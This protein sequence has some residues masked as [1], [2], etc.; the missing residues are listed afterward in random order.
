[1]KFSFRHVE[2]F[3]AVMSSGSATAAAAMLYTSQPTISRELSRFEKLTGLELFRRA[4]SKLVPTEQA[5]MLYDEVQRS[6]FGL[7]RIA[8]AADAIRH[9]RQTQLTVICLP[10]LSHGLLP[11]VCQQLRRRHTGISISVT[12]QESPALQEALSAQ[13]YHLG[14]TEDKEAP[15]GTVVEVL[16]QA[17]VVCVLPAGHALCSRQVLELEDFEGQDFVCLAAEDPYRI[18]TDKLFRERGVER[19][20]VV[21]THSASA[22]CATVNLGVGIA[23]VNPLTA[24]EYAPRGLQIRRLAY[25][26]PYTV[27]MVSPQHRPISAGVA[28][29][30]AIL[31]D[32]CKDMGTRLSSL[33]RQGG[34]F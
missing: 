5:L 26:I 13:R 1:M 28:E 11:Q 23:I 15:P 10:A 32:T 6:Y 31:R 3:G 16:L 12:P 33:A 7:Q 2:I 30:A 20:M 4:G 24:L 9:H 8:N 22:V 29:L 17:D 18:R 34:G 25:S 14:L 21:E 19:H 27:S